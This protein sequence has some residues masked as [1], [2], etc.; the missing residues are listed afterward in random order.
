MDC[1]PVTFQIRCKI[2]SADPCWKMADCSYFPA[3][4]LWKEFGSTLFYCLGCT[5][6]W[7]LSLQPQI[8]HPH[9]EGRLRN[10]REEFQHPVWCRVGDTSAALSVSFCCWNL[11]FSEGMMLVDSQDAG[12]T[13]LRSCLGHRWCALTFI[14]YL[15]KG[16][17]YIV[18]MYCAYIYIHTLAYNIYM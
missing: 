4:F 11:P 15:I 16:G 12:A 8:Y 6:P 9:F 5:D 10:L 7:E 14:R 13:S 3:F 17:I 1:F 18:Y 2:T